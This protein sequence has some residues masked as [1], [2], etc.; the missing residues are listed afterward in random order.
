VNT[1]CGNACAAA[2]WRSFYRPGGQY[3]LHGALPAHGCADAAY[4][5]SSRRSR[6]G[7][8]VMSACGLPVLCLIATSQC[9]GFAQDPRVASAISTP[10]AG[11]TLYRAGRLYPGHT[12][13]RP[14]TPAQTPPTRKAA[15]AVALGAVVMS[16]C[17]CWLR[18]L[19]LVRAMS[20]LRE[21]SESRCRISGIDAARRSWLNHDARHD[22][23]AASAHYTCTAYKG[24]SCSL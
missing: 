19:V 3:G 2:Q 22:W 23:S 13:R 9:R 18:L 20:W 11:L 14:R 17:G 12:A 6:P 8:V 16:A 4:S 10:H 24:F 21:E 1:S 5:Q 15:G 7:A